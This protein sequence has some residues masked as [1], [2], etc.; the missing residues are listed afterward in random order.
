MKK[1]KPDDQNIFSDEIK[2]KIAKKNYSSLSN[3]FLMRASP[4]L[5]WFYM[6][7]KNYVKEILETKSNEKYLELYIKIHDEM[8]KDI[9]I[10]HPNPELPKSGSL[11]I[12]MGL[13]AMEQKYSG[14]E[15]IKMTQNLLNNNYFTNNDI[16]FKIK[17][18]FEN[19]VTEISKPN[20]SKDIF[21]GNLYEQMGYYM[22]SFNLTVYYLYVF[23]EQKKTM[24]LKDIYTN[25][26]YDIS[27]FGGDTDTNGAIVGMVMGPL[28][29]MENFERK[30]F[31]V[32]LNFYSRERII[33]T[34][35]FMYFYARHLKQIENG[36]QLINN[37]KY[38]VNYVVISILLDMLNH[39]IH[40][41]KEE[42]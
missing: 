23:D 15:I 38:K 12:F 2:S 18:H 17:T 33:Y 35:A 27:D 21:F 20:F 9:Q 4:L 40:W 13:C 16:L 41:L 6:V 30:Y 5:T 39:E 3:G 22:H 28:I 1:V 32:F 24:S 8:S 26:M 37:D 29:G 19:L 10:T 14:Q 31:D 25:M 11:M 42:K 7:N 34:N 36:T